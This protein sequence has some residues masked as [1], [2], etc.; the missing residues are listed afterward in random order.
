MTSLHQPAERRGVGFL[1]PSQFKLLDS[2]TDSTG[3]ATNLN[4]YPENL[5]RRVGHS[6]EP[7]KALEVAQFPNC[8][9]SLSS[10]LEPEL[11]D[12]NSLHGFSSIPLTEAEIDIL[13]TK[14]TSM[15][16]GHNTVSIRLQII[17]KNQPKPA[18]PT[19]KLR[20]RQFER[21]LRNVVKVYRGAKFICSKGADIT[22]RD[23]HYSLVDNHNGN[24]DEIAK[25]RVRWCF[26][27]EI[28][29]ENEED[30][31]EDE[32]CDLAETDHQSAD[33]DG[34]KETSSKRLQSSGSKY[35]RS[36]ILKSCLRR[37]FVIGTSHYISHNNPTRR[38]KCVDKLQFV[39]H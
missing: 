8:R 11:N 16:R 32:E 4:L 33:N 25:K 28:L 27:P 31:S 24:N 5:Q 19:Q 22:N 10:L 38:T 2:T 20:Q 9:P 18:S 30:W 21:N 37:S 13:T 34:D 14:N 23:T 3:R 26:L 12:K 15:N 17:K 6:K 1:Q 39:N 35:L 29:E 36:T 7:F